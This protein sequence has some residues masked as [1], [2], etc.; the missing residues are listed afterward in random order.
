M[1]L[2]AAEILKLRKRRAL[3]IWSALLALG[4][5]IVAY[6]VLLALHAANPDKHGPAGSV[7]NL[8]HI[9]ALIAGLGGIAAIIVGT[10]AGTQDVAAGVYRDL[11]VTGRSRRALFAARAPGAAAVY[12]PFLA[13]SFLL[14]V[15]GSFAFADGGATPGAGE[16]GREAIWIGATGLL[17]V[18]LGVALGAFVP[19][20]VA[21]GVL[22]GWG[23]IAAPL[24]IGIGAL[25]GARKWIDVA[26][27]SHFA[28]SDMRPGNLAMSAGMAVLVIL[29]WLAIPLQLGALWTERRDA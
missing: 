17:N 9:L 2:L 22:I 10:T 15:G 25:G 11:V 6:I 27:T 13:L 18:A 12:L 20:R 21:V 24:L 23:V 19:S 1:R 26:A 8:R 29:L 4:P 28:P 16:I 5:T 14:A 7:D 3:M